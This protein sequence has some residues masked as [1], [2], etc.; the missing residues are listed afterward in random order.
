MI[1]F[2][3]TKA[4]SLDEAVRLLSQEEG[5]RVLAGGTDLIPLM[6]EELVSPPTL[7][8]ISD[9]AGSNYIEV[10]SD[11]LHIGALTPL[12][13]IVEHAGV[14]QNYGALAD[15]CRLAASPQLRNMGTIGGNLLQQTRCWYFRGPLDCWLKG[16]SVCFARNGENQPHSIFFTQPGASPCVSAHPSDPAAALLALG[17]RINLRS[18]Q[19][20]RDI[21]VAE[22]FALP[23]A[24]HRTF[25]RLPVAGVI[26]DII[27][28]APPASASS[29]Y[30][31]AMPRA[32]WSFAL[33]GVALYMEIDGG[34][35]GRARVA[36]SGVAP[37]PMHV[38]AVEAML[39]GRALRDLDREKLA[40]ALVQDAQPLS[41]N[42]YK[43]GLVRALFL[44]AL[45]EVLS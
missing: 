42:E 12:S 36:L 5:A 20:E 23:D 19:G 15:A 41:Q 4:R 14:A 2:D 6:K 11:G 22:L 1:N 26:T 38:A 31:K 3:Y 18:P 9:L 45:E 32:A 21:S 44:E 7:I 16:G 39:E 17:A 33:A 13:A 8:D 29:V 25:T 30:L 10:Q 24:A 37:I 43:I 40:S 27:V 35:I 34:R 28:P